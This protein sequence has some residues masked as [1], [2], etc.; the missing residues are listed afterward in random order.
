MINFGTRQQKERIEEHLKKLAPFSIVDLGISYAALGYVK[1][2]SRASNK[3]HGTVSDKE[4]N[5]YSVL[6]EIVA[7]NEIQADCSCCKREDMKEQWC[8]HAIA[9]LWRAYDL[10]FFD[11]NS[12]FA[13]NESTYRSASGTPFEIASVINDLA[14]NSGEALAERSYTPEVSIFIDATSDRLGVQVHFDERMQLPAVFG[15]E[16]QRSS[17]E[18][19][20]L[21]LQ[22]LDE[23]GT[24]DAENK[25]WYVNSSNHIEIVLGLLREYDR[26][27]NSKNNSKISLAPD[28]LH[29]ELHVDWKQSSVD[30]SILWRLP[31]QK[32]R[33][34]EEELIGTGP[35]WTL[36]DD[37]LY[38][39]SPKASRIAALFPLA[40]TIS[41][42]KGQAG[43]ILESLYSGFEAG[44]IVVIKNES[45]QPEAQVKSPTPVLNLERKDTHYE[46]FSARTGFEMR[47]GLNFKYPT[48]SD[49]D[50]LVYLPDRQKEH[51]YLDFLRSLGFEYDA[52]K[53]QFK[54]SG[55]AALNLV[56]EGK[57]M[58][59]RPWKVDGLDQ[60]RKAV[61]FAD[62]SVNISLSKTHNK[63]PEG[64]GI[65]WFDCHVSLTQN[66]ANVP[67][68]LLF[69]NTSSEN[70]K[71][72]KLDSGAYATV[73]GGS[74][75]Q[76]KR[77]LGLLDSQFRLS[78]SIKTTVSPAQA[79]SLSVT[80]T[81][82]FSLQLDET[83]AAL[84]HKLKDFEQIESIKPGK[85]FDGKLRSYQ[86]DGLSWLNFLHDL[87]LGGILAD[88]MGLGK[89]VQT[90]AL[91]QYLKD[92]RKKGKKL[93]K[94]ALVV[95]PT[96]VVTNWFYES[97]K[98]APKLKLLLLH[99]SK[100]KLLFDSISSSDVVL[101]T[102]ALLR[103]DRH[104]LNKH[105]FSYIILD[106]A[107]N[108][109]NP[110]AS[111]TSAAKSLR[112]KH[113]LILTG[114]P[115]ENRPMELWSLFDFLMPGYLGSR[116]FFRH[117]VEK[118]IME[119]GTG[120][121]VA[122]FLRQKTRPFILRRTK[123]QVEK[124]LPAKTE[125]ILHVE[126]TPEQKALY[127]EILE[128]V[129]PK[130][131]N[132]V[133]SK[134]L[135]GATISILS[136]L[137]RLR[138]IC[139]HPNSI[140]ALKN[141]EGYGSGKFEALKT[142]VAEALQSGRK[143]LLFSQF[144][145]MLSIIRRWLDEEEAQYLYLDGRT[146]DRQSLIDQFNSDDDVRL[147]L[148]SLKAGGTGLNLTGADTVIIYDPWWNPAVENQA[149]DRAHRIGQTKAVSVYRLV[150]EDSVEKKI[151]DLKQKKSDIVDALINENALQNLTLS[152]SD[153]ENL[154]SPLPED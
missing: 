34:K 94:P 28:Y 52:Q 150:T 59:P 72:I 42:P 148:I 99:G 75:H 97:K 57:S 67:L 53:R 103:Q 81:N 141:I 85:K 93:D 40:S 49:R 31:N 7:S 114:T 88:E 101:T 71:W 70:S 133:D 35:F 64:S 5:T 55:D 74:L 4:A 108:I 111:T 19:D 121:E 62:L 110:H 154:F 123:A 96:S 1:E 12:G 36:I 66:N 44:D 37:V 86:E 136:A 142:L 104:E 26:V 119:L 102:Y 69:K 65:D 83:L 54:I 41:Y 8:Q 84:T 134:G 17:R 39:L 15:D 60:I 151:M 149:I 9:L 152:K 128:E 118:P 78:N 120:G 115:T 117:Q 137:L 23:E 138:Q 79:I 50:N 14:D 58:F 77:G 16:A 76:L 100:R 73:P 89:T 68:S 87:E 20:N 47:A 143:I 105:E 18:L 129:R 38:R 13:T 140:S 139:N 51:E 145:E 32:T 63:N 2:C 113:R 132:A 95:S 116:E 43:P 33:N 127:S 112:A 80:K 21:L 27:L 125:S 92:S 98:F 90:L 153:L 10:G 61:K 122:D 107:Q 11:T 126:M 29:A 144:R 6:L 130:V 135:R 3:I 82:G 22:I 45:L 46:H 25:F 91:L 146:K 24:W 147:F 48:P 131:F 124:D 109:K 56:Y 30:L 106:E